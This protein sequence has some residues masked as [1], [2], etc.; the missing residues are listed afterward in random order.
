MCCG[1]DTFYIVSVYI[2]CQASIYTL[3]LCR[4]NS[5]RVRLAK[6]ETLTPPGH[7]VSPLVCRCPWMST[8]VLYCYCIS[9]FVFYIDTSFCHANYSDAIVSG[10]LPRFH[11]PTFHQIPVTVWCVLSSD[12]VNI[13]QFTTTSYN[14]RVIKVK[15]VAVIVAAY[16]PSTMTMI[17][18]SIC[19]QTSANTLKSILV[20]DFFIINIMPTRL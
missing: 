7:L 3:S 16:N 12:L 13:I 19:R 5:W 10:R 15:G 20:Q 1:C 4:G 9:S 17:V 2:Q 14:R 6:Q 18:W 8:V 11:I